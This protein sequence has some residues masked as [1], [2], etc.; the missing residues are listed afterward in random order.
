MGDS[1]GMRVS[2]AAPVCFALPMIAVLHAAPVQTETLFEQQQVLFDDLVQP[3]TYEQQEELYDSLVQEAASKGKGAKNAPKK[4]TANANK[5]A[6]DGEKPTKDW[7]PNNPHDKNVD[8]SHKK[9]KIDQQTETQDEILAP[10][11]ETQARDAAQVKETK[12]QKKKLAADAKK[13]LADQ[14]K[15]ESNAAAIVKKAKSI[16]T[17]VNEEEITKVNKILN[18]KPKQEMENQN[19]FTADMAAAAEGGEPL[20]NGAGQM[21]T[22]KEIGNQYVETNKPEGK[23]AA[24]K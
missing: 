16:G 22:G 12:I 7:D 6:D 19:H 10:L 4:A 17:K 8:A 23:K 3:T 24:G 20:P 13:V 9:R 21:E 5:Q 15:E 1:E 18:D 11:K 14:K 2:E